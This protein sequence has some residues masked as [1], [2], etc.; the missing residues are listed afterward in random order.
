[1]NQ[2]QNFK[3]VNIPV[4]VTDTAT[5]DRNNTEIRQKIKVLSDVL[6]T[7]PTSDDTPHSLSKD[8]GRDA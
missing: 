6:I 8:I 7:P 5:R 3:Q 2:N 4:T 1:M